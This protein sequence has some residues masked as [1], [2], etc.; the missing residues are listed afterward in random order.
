MNWG[1]SAGLAEKNGRV[2]QFSNV[3]VAT[4]AK[5][6]SPANECKA[7][8]GLPGEGVSGPFF[9]SLAREKNI[10]QRCVIRSCRYGLS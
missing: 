6:I 10:G 1:A 3:T 4:S 8:H 7:G 2:P 5:A 9:G